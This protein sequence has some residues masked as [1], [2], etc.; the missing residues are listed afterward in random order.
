MTF[1]G[2]ASTSTSKVEIKIGAGS[3]T[4]V[5]GTTAWSHSWDTKTVLDG[6]YS[7]RVRAFDG[8]SYSTEQVVSVMVWNAPPVGPQQP[9]GMETS[10]AIGL[11][12]A[13]LVIGL[14]IGVMIS[15]I[16]GR[17]AP[18]ERDEPEPEP[19]AEVEEERS[20]KSAQASGK[21]PPLKKEA[22]EEDDE[23]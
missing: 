13:L 12:L 8:T 21:R 20:V 4:A 18:V 23:V 5:T 14:A 17:P 9:A 15:K 11:A 22:M 6:A 19:A 3:W 1:T 16:R 10:L 2:T 7:I